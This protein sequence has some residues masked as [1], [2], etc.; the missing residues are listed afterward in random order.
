MSTIWIREEAKDKIEILFLH[1]YK[2]HELLI[3]E[4]TEKKRTVLLRF[5]KRIYFN[6]KIPIVSIKFFVKNVR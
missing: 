6:N 1:N 4:S 5:S 3:E 2:K